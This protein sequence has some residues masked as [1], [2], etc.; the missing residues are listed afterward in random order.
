[1]ADSEVQAAASA[2]LVGV[3]ATPKA[4]SAEMVVLAIAP[5]EVDSATPTVVSASLAADSVVQAVSAT[6]PKVDLATAQ[7]A[8][9][10]KSRPP[11]M[12]P[13]FQMMSTKM[14]SET[15]L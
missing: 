1:M 14:K 3:S 8:V 15:T 12:F 9:V 5:A 10:V 4:A 11:C 13:V 2:T 7:A 6:V